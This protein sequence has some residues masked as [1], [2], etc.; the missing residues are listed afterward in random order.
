MKEFFGVGGYARVPEGYMSWQH[1]TF[2]SALMVIM[3]LCAVLLGKKYRYADEKQKSKALIWAALLIDGIEIL[4]IVVMCLRSDD[5][6]STLLMELPLFLCSIQLITI[7]LAAFSKGRI[8]QAALDFVFIF[9]VLGAVL[10]TYAAGQNYACY[11]VLSIDNVASGI[12]HSISGF[13]ALYIGFSGLISMNR[14]NCGIT[15]GILGFFCCTAY[16]VNIIVDYN[17]MFLMAGDG[18]P[19][20]LLYNLVGGSPVLYPI[21]VVALLLIY[22]IVFYVA[23]YFISKKKHAKITEKTEVVL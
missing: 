14:K 21:G 8:R 16:I 11:P 10:G 23:H 20:D 19:Y 17:Y 3:T 18:T 4:K 1:L 7:P 15:F 5:V 9:G 2:V 6:V 22:I 12:T 13:S